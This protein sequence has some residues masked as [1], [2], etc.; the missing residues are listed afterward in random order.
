VRACSSPER[1]LA[2]ASL[3]LVAAACTRCERAPTSVAAAPAQDAD[4]RIDV[5]RIEDFSPTG[6]PS[7]SA[8]RPAPSLADPG[9][10]GTAS[11][12]RGTSIG[13]TSVVFKVELAGPLACAF[14]PESRRGK[15]RY[16]GEIAAYRLG[17][18]LGI[19]NVPPAFPRTFLAPA[20][21]A[22]LD[23]P[24]RTLFD[25]E[26][27]VTGGKVRGAAMPWIAKLEFIPLESAT[28]R[29]RWQGWL[30]HGTPMP[31]GADREL[32]GQISTLIV[33]DTLT[34][35]W[36]RWSGANVAIDRRT[37][38]L[39][40]MD[41]DGAFFDPVPPGPLAA[42]L[43][44]LKK[45]DRFSRSLVTTLR[46]L[47]AEKLAAAFGEEEPGRALLPPRVV[48]GVDDRRRQVLAHVDARVAE[49]GE[50]AVLAF[51]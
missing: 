6:A 33:F 35:N 11:P 9:A 24:G 44:L 38:T 13:H 18:A 43:A 5:G 36:D 19:G 28:W 7:A 16:R 14:K 4:A 20:L 25:A 34:G 47:D 32:A 17:V 30:A 12:T 51:P 40:F 46:A 10:Y 50:P 41:N 37:N 49:L 31:E 23:P 39:L 3:L 22:V 8:V 48:A 26:A 42:Q 15:T 45:T 2:A 29:S 27:I 1:L 21:A